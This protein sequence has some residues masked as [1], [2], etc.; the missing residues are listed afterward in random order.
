MKLQLV[1]KFLCKNYTI[2]D[3]YIDDVFF[4]N[5]LEDRVR[6]EGE[7]KVYG[8]TAIAFG[9]YMVIITYSNHFKRPL[10]LILNV[11]EF[12]GVRMH[13]GNTEMDTLGCI[14]VGKNTQKGMV[15][16]SAMTE[17]AL[18]KKLSGQLKIELEII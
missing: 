14:L 9:K 13:R 4:C 3:L 8:E 11:P 7:P 2:G 6:E 17:K 10:P 16:S 1:R 5:T 12:E 15:T 18:M